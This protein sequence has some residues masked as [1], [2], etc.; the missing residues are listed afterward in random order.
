MIK[1][2]SVAVV[3]TVCFFVF[4]IQTINSIT[5][6]GFRILPDAYKLSQCS[7]IFVTIPILLILPLS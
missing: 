4:F 2:I 6:N 3:V 5:M 1:S 7:T